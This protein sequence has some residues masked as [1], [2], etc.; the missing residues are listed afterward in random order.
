VQDDSISEVTFE[1]PPR[2]FYRILLVDD[3]PIALKL[4]GSIL[5]NEGYVKIDEAGAGHEALEALERTEY[6]LVL[7]DKNLPGMDGLDVLEFGRRMRPECEF[8]MITAYGS[9]ETAIRAIDLGAFSYVTKPFD[10]KLLAARVERAIDRVATRIENRQLM[11]RL[12]ILL[13]DLARSKEKLAE[14]SQESG[15]HKV[16]LDK[17]HEAV[18]RL[19]LLAGQMD[20]LSVHARGKAAEI[21]EQM[22]KNV[23]EVA[24]LLETESGEPT[25]REDDQ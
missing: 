5:K 15:D 9:L 7:L 20:K 25:R 8:I 10:L 11:D 23:S 1:R 12:R 24:D 13:G 4:L 2:S 19:H 22:G 21:L 6:H 3:E 17:V 16:E 18:K 14:L